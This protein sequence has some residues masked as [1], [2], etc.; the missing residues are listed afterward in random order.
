[1]LGVI[2]GKLDD[3]DVLELEDICF[4][5]YKRFSEFLFST[6]IGSLLL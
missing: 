2:Q 1:M 5:N 4:F 3:D 6:D